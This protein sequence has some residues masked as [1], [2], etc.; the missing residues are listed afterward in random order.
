MIQYIETDKA[1][2]PAGHY[3]Q[4]SVFNGM[5][6]VAGQL[7]IKP[8]GRGKEVGSIEEQSRQVIEN[9]K[10]ILEAAGSDLEHTLR[11]TIYIS[12]IELWG[13]VNAIYTEAFGKATP[14]RAIVP[15]KDLH[16]GYSIEMTA[17]AAVKTPA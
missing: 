6:F 3:A 15:V 13:K 16:Y 5:V 10:N 2:L 4:A 1:P 9:V 12:D 7:P 11:V 14:A 17:I 8:G